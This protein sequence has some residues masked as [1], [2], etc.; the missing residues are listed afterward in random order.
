MGLVG[1]RGAAVL[2]RPRDYVPL[3]SLCCCCRWDG[4]GWGRKLARN[5]NDRG[6]PAIPISCQNRA[7]RLPRGKHFVAKQLHSDGKGVPLRF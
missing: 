6:T 7:R 1:G 5:E 4:G 2:P 3:P